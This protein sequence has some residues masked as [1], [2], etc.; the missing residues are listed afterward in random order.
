MSRGRSITTDLPMP[1]CTKRE[2][3]SRA[4]DAASDAP[5]VGRAIRADRRPAPDRAPTHAQ[6]AASERQPSRIVHVA[7]SLIPLQNSFRRGHGGDAEAHH[8]DPGLRAGGAL[9]LARQRRVARRPRGC[10]ARATACRAGATARASRPGAASVRASRSCRSRP[11][12][13]PSRRASGRS[14]ARGCS[15]GSSRWCAISVPPAFSASRS[16]RDRI[17]STRS[18]GRM[19]PPAPVSGE[20]SVETARMPLSSTAAMKPEPLALISL[21]SRIGSP[22]TNGARAIAPVSCSIASGLLGSCG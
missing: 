20:I 7:M 14:R 8:V 9:V 1:S 21:A 16:R 10:A 17:T 11:S 2:P 13:R 3:E 5:R 18:F 15:P 12:G 4:D 19:K 22:A 6:R